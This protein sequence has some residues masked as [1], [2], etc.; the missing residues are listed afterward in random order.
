[1]PSS[2]A[3]RSTRPSTAGPADT[4]AANVSAASP[5]EEVNPATPPALSIAFSSARLI[6]TTCAGTSAGSIRS[7]SRASRSPKNPSASPRD[8]CRGAGTF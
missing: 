6:R 8:T 2:I 4:A 1:M 5:A 7:A 3:E